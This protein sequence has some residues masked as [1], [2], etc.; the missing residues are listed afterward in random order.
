MESERKRR[1]ILIFDAKTDYLMR[2]LEL[3]EKLISLEGIGGNEYF[4][5]DWY[6]SFIAYCIGI[7]VCGLVSDETF[8]NYNSFES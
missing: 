1:L 7:W 3:S 6:P 2:L 8:S 4:T 5:L